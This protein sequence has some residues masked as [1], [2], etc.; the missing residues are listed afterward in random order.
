MAAQKNIVIVGANGRLGQALQKVCAGDRVI[1]LT[2]AEAD[3]SQVGSVA[4][5]LG[6][7]EFD[8]LLMAAA[9]TDVDACEREP[10]MAQRLNA[11][12]PGECARLAAQRGARMIHFSTDY[13]FDGESNTPYTES[14]ATNPQ[15]VYGSSKLAGEQ[16]VLAA[17]DDHLA[18]RLAWLY[19]PGGENAT[20]DWVIPTAK[21]GKPLKLVDD[22]VGS[23]SYSIDIAE[24]VAGLFFH[25]DAKGVLHLSNSGDCS[26]IEWARECLRAACEVGL[27]DPVPEIAA[28]SLD[29]CFAGK[30]PRPR[31]SVMANN[32]YEALTGSRLR[33]WSDAVHSYVRDFVKPRLAG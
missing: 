6:D 15:S 29:Q 28:W 2:R 9:M 5:A 8:L 31:Y 14:D 24:A 16:A 25:P 32:R 23:P 4:A 21:A 7:R 12:A 27:I 11:D 13:V 22:K 18:V 19:G 10:D 33:P 20:P 3:L 30:A 26:W 17:S 1:A